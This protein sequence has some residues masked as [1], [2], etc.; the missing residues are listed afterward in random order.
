MI[1]FYNNVQAS[2]VRNFRQIYV[3]TYMW[4]TKL[5]IFWRWSAAYFNL[6]PSLHV[7]DLVSQV[8]DAVLVNV[9]LEVRNPGGSGFWIGGIWARKGK[10]GVQFTS[11]RE[12]RWTDPVT[13]RRVPSKWRGI[14]KGS[15]GNAQGE[16][17]KQGECVKYI[18]IYVRE[19]KWMLVVIEWY[20]LRMCII[21]IIGMNVLL[22]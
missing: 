10:W 21:I 4:P 5:K 8:R 7:L 6:L 16:M 2:N 18:V 14:E 20:Q 15:K 11:N 19:Y 22:T 3:A 17:L 1:S 12:P 13:A 9:Y